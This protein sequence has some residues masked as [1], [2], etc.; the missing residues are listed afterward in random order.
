M[1]PE[2]YLWEVL[3]AVK[4]NEEKMHARD[5]GHACLWETITDYAK[6]IIE[7]N[8]KL[9][10]E[11]VGLMQKRIFWNKEEDGW[12]MQDGQQKAVRMDKDA[13]KAKA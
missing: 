6:S 10:P 5:Q 13:T 12:Y 11:I 7:K 3:E 1:I 9:S 2:S 4:R 8:P